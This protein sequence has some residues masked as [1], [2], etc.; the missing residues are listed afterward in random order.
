[1]YTL[2]QRDRDKST[3]SNAVVL[4]GSARIQARFEMTPKRA[5]I[6]FSVSVVAHGN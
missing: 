4:C 1:M 3:V 5:C 2:S 6:V